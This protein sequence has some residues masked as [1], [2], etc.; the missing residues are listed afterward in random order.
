MFWS[1]LKPPSSKIKEPP[2]ER[3]HVFM[4]R[5]VDG[6]L[7][8]SVTHDVD[9]TLSVINTGQGPLY[10][11]LRRPVF[12]VHSEEFMN[13]RDALRR[14]EYIKRLNRQAKESLLSDLLIGALDSQR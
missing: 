7:Y 1:L 12:L 8:A 2:L 6:S 13:E 14:V 5:C 4:V 11:R 9:E 3:W 10:T